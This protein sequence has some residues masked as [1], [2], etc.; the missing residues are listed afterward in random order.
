MGIIIPRLVLVNLG[1]EAN[2]LLSSVNQALVYLNLLEA[3]IGTATLQALY[4]PVARQDH[5]AINGVLAATH[6]YYKKVGTWY[7]IAVCALSIVYAFSVK[8]TMPIS[9]VMAVIFFSGMSQLAL[10]YDTFPGR[11]N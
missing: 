7:F 1:S 6:K 11:K 9:V 4:A 2:G 10:E 3:G 5:G 8:S